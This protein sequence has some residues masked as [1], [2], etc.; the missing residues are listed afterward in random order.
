MLFI[1]HQKEKSESILTQAVQYFANPPSLHGN[2]CKKIIVLV[3]ERYTNM[4]IM[5]RCKADKNNCNLGL[6]KN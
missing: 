6:C 5:P 1:V 4:L 3:T 2:N